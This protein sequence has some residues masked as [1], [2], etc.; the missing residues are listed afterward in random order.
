MN[1]KKSCFQHSGIRCN[2][3][4]H[5]ILEYSMHFNEMKLLRDS[6]KKNIK[7]H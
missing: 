3:I 6:I 1:V 2:V 5:R 4:E 7:L